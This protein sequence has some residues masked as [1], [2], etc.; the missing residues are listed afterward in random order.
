MGAESSSP[1]VLL[2]LL[3]CSADEPAGKRKLI[4]VDT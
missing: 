4:T 3:T 1:P 2:L